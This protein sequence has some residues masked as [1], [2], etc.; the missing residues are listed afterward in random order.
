MSC[1]FVVSYVMC[2]VLS[3]F[4]DGTGM[5]CSDSGVCFGLVRYPQRPDRVEP[6]KDAGC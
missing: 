2:I 4:V 5:L 1:V 6:V 3:L